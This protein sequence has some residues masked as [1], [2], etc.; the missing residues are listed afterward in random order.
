[1][2]TVRL[3]APFTGWATALDEVADPIFSER[4]LGDGIA[5]DPFEGVVRAPC[6]GLIVAVAETH[7]SVTLRTR[8]DAEIL[9]HFGIDT[10][11]LAGNGF[12]RSV[13]PG[14]QVRQGDRLFTV[15]LDSV[16][17]R[18]TSLITPIVCLSKGYA[19]KPLAQGSVAAG[20]PLFDLCLLERAP[21]NQATANV[22]TAVVISVAVHLI[23]GI[24]ARPAARIAATLKS[25]SAEVRIETK[26][27]HANARSVASVLALDIRRGDSIAVVGRGDNAAA[28]VAALASLIESGMGE[29]VAA[30]S[31]PTPPITCTPANPAMI[32]AVRAAPG[33][34][35][36]FAVQYRAVE[37]VIPQQGQG[38]DR[39]QAK[40]A[41]ALNTL[42]TK[43]MTRS[44][45]SDIAAA[46][47]ALLEDP[48]LQAAAHAAMARGESA[49][50]A[51][52]S[53][54]RDCANTLRATGNPRLIERIADLL[55]VESQLA[56]TL[57]GATAMV[58]ILPPD[59]IL[60]TDEL[61]PST[62][63]ALDATPLAG[64]ITAAGGP[65]AHVALLAAA[66]GVPM[67]VSAG[68]DVLA[69]ADGTPLILD[70]NTGA[71]QIAP[72]E[73]RTAAA[74]RDTVV[75]AARERLEAAASH[76]LCMMADGTRIEVFANCAS[77][78]ETAAAVAAG[79]EG[80][81]LLRTEFLFLDR[82]ERPDED[83]Q[84]RAY[85]AI[86]ARLGD[87]PLI[88]RTLDIGAD[89]PV[90]YLP[91]PRE[92]NPALG[93][94][95]IRLSLARPELLREQFRAILRGVPAGQCRI[96]LP[97]VVD[98]DEYRQ[99]RALLTE[100]MQTVGTAAHV[101]L[102]IMV[103][104][105]AAAL[106]SA[107]L[108]QEVDFI[109][110]GS[111]DLTQYTL[112]ADR[113]NPALAARIDAL[114]PAVL[115]LIAMSAA[116]AHAAGR[117]VGLCGALASDPQAAALLIG[118]G[119]DELSATPRA[120]P[121][122]KAQI[123]TLTGERCRALATAALAATSAAAVRQLIEEFR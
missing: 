2:T 64:I 60:I 37:P 44:E 100:A 117:W 84:V 18:A 73:E 50:H 118:L 98:A 3:A 99:A 101:P 53:A 20:A 90:S 83:E 123:R 39:E 49:A 35:I 116:G 106:L 70:A 92:D 26:G 7:H 110:I 15:D 75:R 8:H 76:A 91:L 21:S 80:C 22:E 121:A 54:S 59:S 34:A 93:A 19:L 10:V 24:H 95:G 72:G 96:M 9:I 119:I 63:L 58:P 71:V 38:F 77:A 28:A 11:A 88:V 94:R 112:A 32:Q 85:A 68:L 1:M 43:L 105:P 4:M 62:F 56:L 69:I 115:R 42:T 55:D 82:A 16:V 47:I 120:I 12:E 48:E 107:E 114:H 45:A 14:M 5:L 74:R 17:A 23:N 86:A 102:G 103:E 36:G 6:D 30:A 51:W 109:S 31:L 67:V 40:L 89:K 78:E 66:H 108:A 46:H 113:G 13:Q 52:R 57:E 27:R 79:A 61:L 104:T 87:R 29:T 41:H 25:F 65:T 122:L 97:M 111:N 33:H 81:G